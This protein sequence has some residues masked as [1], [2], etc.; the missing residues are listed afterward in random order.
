MLGN[1]G[2][3]SKSNLPKINTKEQ[4]VEKETK[5]DDRYR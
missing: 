3:Y 2:D 5:E 1:D 4:I